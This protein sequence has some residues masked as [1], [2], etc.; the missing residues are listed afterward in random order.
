MKRFFLITTMIAFSLSAGAQTKINVRFATAAETN[1]Q[2]SKTSSYTDGWGKFDIQSRAGRVDATFDELM[3]FRQTQGVDIT[4]AEQD[5]L[6]AAVHQIEKFLDDNGYFIPVPEEVVIAKTTMNEEGNAGGYTLENWIYLGGRLDRRAPVSLVAH[7]LN[8]VLTRNNPQYR[9]ALYKTIGFEVIGHEIE[10]PQDVMDKKISNPDVAFYDSYAMLTVGGKK[11]PCTMM[12]Y[13]TKDYK[14]MVGQSFFRNMEI[15]LIPLDEKFEPVVEN[16]K[17]VIY[18]LDECPDF[19]DLVGKNTGYV[20]NPEECLADNFALI[21]A[22]GRRA[23]Q[24]PELLEQIKE[25]LRKQW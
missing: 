23:P 9:A 13:S 8:H 16:G 15:G 18:P 21:F 7:E 3:A 25:I 20:I 2:L 11:Q 22:P 14:D 1:Q 10:F 4:Q 24:T 19:Y 17:T 6:M 12:I 5:S